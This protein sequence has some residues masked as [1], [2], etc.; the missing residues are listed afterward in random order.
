MHNP[1]KQIQTS[2]TL[3]L[4]LLILPGRAPA[5]VGAP[6][7]A[8][9]EG[10]VAPG[11]STG[12]RFENWHRKTK[13]G[14]RTE[15]LKM[16]RATATLQIPLQAGSA[17]WVEGGWNNPE[18]GG[19]ESR[20][21]MTWGLGAVGRVFRLAHRADPERGPQDWT[22]LR[23]EASARSG[24]APADGK[25]DIEWFLW[26]GRVG[27][28]WHQLYRG[29]HKGPMGAT[30]LTVD[31]GLIW[32]DL[33]AEREGFKGSARQDFGVYTR[34]LFSIQD[35]TFFGLEADWMSGADR[36]YGLIAGFRF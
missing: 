34:A 21:G 36:R 15:A 29:A 8:W 3:V 16:T 24:D 9:V 19:E 32:N 6:E 25:G 33:T 1:I 17:V 2:L 5:Q 10:G 30:A 26:E 18:L 31:A 13:T 4:L 11:L 12:V 20:G 22:A 35:Q 23:V 27:L 7:G 14:N 28:E